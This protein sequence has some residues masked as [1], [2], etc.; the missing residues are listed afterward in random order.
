MFILS[1][2][3]ECDLVNGVTC[4]NLN[5]LDQNGVEE[6]VCLQCPDGTAGDGRECRGTQHSLVFPSIPHLHLSPLSLPLS[7]HP[8]LS[9][10]S[11]PPLI[12][13]SHPFPPLHPSTYPSIP[14]FPSPPSLP[15]SFHPTLSLLS[16]PPLI[17]PSHP[18]PP[19]H[20]SPYPFIPPFPSPPFQLPS[21]TFLSLYPCYSSF[22]FP[23]MPFFFHPYLLPS[24]LSPSPSLTSI[25]SLSVSPFITHACLHP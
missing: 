2:F 19:L 16:I 10:P 22:I 13:P 12:L 7:F 11:I 20:L 23:L 5:F 17:L 18:F 4:V 14:S 15:L 21:L 24:C 3:Q 1:V 9:L 25:S 8:T 6:S